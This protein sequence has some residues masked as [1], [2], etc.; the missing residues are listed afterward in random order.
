MDRFMREKKLRTD[1]VRIDHLQIEQL[2]FESLPCRS[3][4]K[5]FKW[6]A[7]RTIQSRCQS[8]DRISCCTDDRIVWAAHKRFDLC[9]D[10]FGLCFFP[11]NVAKN[12]I[13]IWLDMEN[14]WKYW[15]KNISRWWF[16]SNRENLEHVQFQTWNKFIDNIKWIPK[17]FFW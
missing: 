17:F 3:G 13:P 6:L 4:W 10:D 15:S 16:A 1:F 9:M 12:V 7:F 2:N 14:L 8:F 11:N 5:R